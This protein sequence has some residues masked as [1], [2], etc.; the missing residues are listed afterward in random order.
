MFKVV[1]ATYRVN[2]RPED[3]NCSVYRNVGYLSIFDAAYT[4]IQS[5][6]LSSG[7][8]DQRTSII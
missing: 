1:V 5:C 4:E 2:I 3:G 8:E 7:R 6:T